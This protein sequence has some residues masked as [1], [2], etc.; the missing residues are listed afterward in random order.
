MVV[1]K[2]AILQED[3]MNNLRL[4]HKMQ[5]QICQW[6]PEE[7]ITRVRNLSLLVVGLYLGRGVHLSY[8]VRKWPLPGKDLSLINRLRR[9]LSNGRIDVRRWYRPVARQLV[10]P[11]AGRP[12]RLI[13][14]CTKVGFRYRVMIVGLTYR[15][16][17][18]PLAWCVYRGQKG[19]V[20][21][22]EQIALLQEVAGLLP[23]NSPIVL[24]GDAG[25]QS[26]SLLRW[27]SRR[28]WVF[29]IRQPGNINVRWAGGSWV[30]INQLPLTE[31][32][33]RLIGWVRLTKKHN[34]GWFWLLLHW[35]QGEDEPWYLVS[36]RSGGSQLVRLYRLRMWIE[37]MY[38]DLKGHGFDLEA[39]HLGCLER[40]NR[41]MLGVCLA[42]VWL[43]SLGSWVV[44]RGLRH[45]ID[46]KSRRDKSYFR[47]GWDWLE[48]CR[49]LH[50]PVPFRFQPYL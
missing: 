50:L 3:R 1:R 21:T 11:L 49:R 42:F 9:F 43:I 47:L 39:T 41:L 18:L 28:H 37:E 32:Q 29:V 34:A 2:Q 22:V 30:K 38:G 8:I 7:R 20:E 19:H 12:I 27:L 14:D 17:T 45:F 40:I 48:R 13:I 46:R 25:F 26:V 24:L 16:R 33:T 15:R 36:N 31:G 35:E 10:Q 6:L 5:Q 23:A 44:K 4:Y